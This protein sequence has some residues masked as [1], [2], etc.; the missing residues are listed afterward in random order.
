[1][2]HRKFSRGFTL[3]E[4][5][6]VIAIIAILIALLLPA[7]Q[8]AREAARRTQCQNNLHQIGLALHNYHDTFLVFPPG[9]IATLFV[10][11]TVDGGS[12]TDRRYADPQEALTKFTFENNLPYHGTSWMLHILPF[13]EQGNVYD[14]WNFQ[15]NL[16][17]N[18]DL[19]LNPNIL[20]DEAPPLTEIR[21]FYCPSR[22]NSMDAQRLNRVR[23][24]IDVEENF[25]WKKGGNDYAGCIGS[26]IG[27]TL[28]EE[29]ENHRGLLHLTTAQLEFES[30]NDPNNLVG[31]V[32]G[33]SSLPAG[34]D[35]GVFYV[36]S[37]S[38]LHSMSDGTS[39][40]FM[41]GERMLLNGDELALRFDNDPDNNEPP[42][43]NDDTVDLQLSSDGWAWGGDATL[44]STRQGINKG[45]H[46]DNAGSD[47]PGG[48]HFA[49]GDGSVKFINENIELRTFRNLG[50]MSNTLPVTNF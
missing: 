16:L 27:W 29:V 38:G 36:N 39:N 43:P 24:V 19:T 13:M 18:G 30:D 45:T 3:I 22:R 49:M 47:H 50:N 46:F 8:Q 35:L 44:F 11:N 4:L 20:L 34:F 9:M 6:V 31:L 15:R 7:V 1:V 14:Q 10:P 17:D 40:V 33:F 26:G 48:A 2:F 42:D 23:R 28:D 21:A 25:E 37:S 5:L 41:V 32:P 12:N